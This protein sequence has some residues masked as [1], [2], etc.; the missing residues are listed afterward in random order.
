[1]N[2][3]SGRSCYGLGDLVGGYDERELDISTRNLA[4]FET[5][6]ERLQLTRLPQGETNSVEVSQ[7]Q[8][9]CILQEEIPENVGISI[10]DGGIHVPRSTSNDE[11]L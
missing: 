4:T 7:A 10:D 2:A 9:T 5:P 8:M 1:M 6:L 3:F 11:A